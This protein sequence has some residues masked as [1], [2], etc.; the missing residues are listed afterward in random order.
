YDFAWYGGMHP[1]SY[2]LISPYIMGVLGVRATM[3]VAGTVSAALVT[4]LLGRLPALNNPVW[5]AAYAALDLTGNARSCRVT[6]GLGVAL[7][8]GALA[9]VFAWPRQKQ[10]RAEVWLRA[11]LTCLLAGLATAASPVAGLFLG[12]VAAALW[13]R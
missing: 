13:L 6:F 9:T 2:S 7:G 4:I 10:S 3:L 1:A 12:L 11:A 8:L 5:A